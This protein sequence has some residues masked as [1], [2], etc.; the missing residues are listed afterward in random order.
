MDFKV[1]DRIFASEIFRLTPTFGVV[2]VH[3][4][5]KIL[6]RRVAHFANFYYVIISFG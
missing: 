6:L 2:R 3:T 4:L 1:G 5:N